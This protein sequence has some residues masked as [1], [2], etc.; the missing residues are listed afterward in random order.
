MQ[1]LVAILPNHHVILTIKS[2]TIAYCIT[3]Y[4]LINVYYLCLCA[5]L[6]TT[7]HIRTQQAGLCVC[8]YWLCIHVAVALLVSAPLCFLCTEQS[9]PGARVTRG[10]LQFN[11]YATVSSRTNVN[12]LPSYCSLAWCLYENSYGL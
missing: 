10:R 3:D 12:H 1:R 7:I 5:F 6:L 11:T 9:C 4:H 2:K 8:M